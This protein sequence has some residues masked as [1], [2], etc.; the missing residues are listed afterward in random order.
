MKRKGFT[1]LEMCKNL[2]NR[3]RLRN[4][5]WSLLNIF[6][7]R[8][9]PYYVRRNEQRNLS[10]YDEKQGSP[11]GITLLE[12]LV[13]LFIMGMIAMALYGILKGGLDV[14]RGGKE[15]TDIIA[16]ARV[17]MDRL[18]REA[19]EATYMKAADITSI[20]FSAWLGSTTTLSDVSYYYDDD[21]QNILYR[22]AK[23]GG[24]VVAGEEKEMAKYMN[25]FSLYYYSKGDD[26]AIHSFD[27]SGAYD[28]IWM[29][30]IK[31]EV[32]K[33][34][35]IVNLRSTVQPRNYSEYHVW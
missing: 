6:R 29:I 32:K 15:R 17:A 28:D 23:A 26:G 12:I 13:V 30:E 5:S 3:L 10:T 2:G 21:P 20:N 25:S 7:Q 34:D 4:W 22:N 18:T 8:T 27:P 11:T 35:N 14:W 16:Q 1:P 9:Q 31:S 24:T 33:D 19:R